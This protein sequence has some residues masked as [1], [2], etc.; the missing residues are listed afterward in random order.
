MRSAPIAGVLGRIVEKPRLK[1]VFLLR[2]D[3]VSS[4][5]ACT[6]QPF[7]KVTRT[8]VK[9]HFYVPIVVFPRPQKGAALAAEFHSEASRTRV[10]QR[11]SPWTIKNVV[12]SRVLGVMAPMARLVTCLGRLGHQ[13]RP[14]SV[15]KASLLLFLL[16]CWFE[17]RVFFASCVVF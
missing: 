16:V 9:L 14:K 10:L 15:P 7:L 4:V 2:T 6:H 5:G 12:F 1:S 8:L 13:N 11:L 3:K 17:G